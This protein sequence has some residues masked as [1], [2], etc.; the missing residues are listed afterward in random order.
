MAT[1]FEGKVA[2]VTGASRG[3]GRA[4]ALA[5]AEGGAAVC[6]LA[7]SAHE[8]DEVARTIRAGGGRALALKNGHWEP[9][10]SHRSRNADPR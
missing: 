7:R 1:I 5:L 9:S 2:L 10:R 4:L 8:L 6:L 3:I